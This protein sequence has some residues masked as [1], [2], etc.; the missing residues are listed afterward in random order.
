MRK[1]L[2]FSPRLGDRTYSVEFRNELTPGSWAPLGGTTQS[3]NGQERT[4][5]DLNATGATKF[6]RIQ[7]NKP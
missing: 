2:I 4:V 1:N 3:D 7:I 6:Y 5:T